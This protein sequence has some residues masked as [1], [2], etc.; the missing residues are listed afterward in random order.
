MSR[1]TAKPLG[2]P[3]FD[4]LRH[5]LAQHLGQ[6]FAEQYP[7]FGVDQRDPQTLPEQEILLHLGNPR[8]QPGHGLEQTVQMLWS[9][10]GDAEGEVKQAIAQRS[11]NRMQSAGQA[12]EDI[13]GQGWRSPGQRMGQ[14]QGFEASQWLEFSP[15]AVGFDA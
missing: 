5:Q 7:G 14:T 15:G 9:G 10:F 11:S 8:H 2:D 1:N 6:V 4:I 3:G 12:F 13:G